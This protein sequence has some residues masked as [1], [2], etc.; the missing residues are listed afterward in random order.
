MG[1]GGRNNEKKRI[2]A[3]QL[4]GGEDMQR[5]RRSESSTSVYVCVCMM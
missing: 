2:E 3:D 1:A 5:G 4:C